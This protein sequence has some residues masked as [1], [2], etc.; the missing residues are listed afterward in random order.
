MWSLTI[1]LFSIEC[2]LYL[3]GIISTFLY[4]Q[5]L[6][7]IF[8]PQSWHEPS[9]KHSLCLSTPC[10]R[11]LLRRQIVPTRAESSLL[12]I[13]RGQPILLGRSQKPILASIER[14]LGYRLPKPRFMYTQTWH[15]HRQGYTPYTCLITMV[16]RLNSS[17]PT[18]P[19][20]F[21]RNTVR[22]QLY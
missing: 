6:T 14:Q 10:P 19:V 12:G 16:S 8:V 5:F 1:L 15:N 9:D 3:G 17:M 18:A 22:I 2:W 20:I 7:S 11:L 21:P 4:Q 13:C